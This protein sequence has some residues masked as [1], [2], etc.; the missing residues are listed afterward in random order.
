ML[1]STSKEREE[2]VGHVPGATVGTIQR[3]AARE[4]WG[5]GGYGC[6]DFAMAPAHHVCECI[7]CICGGPAVKKCYAHSAVAVRGRGRGVELG[8]VDFSRIKKQGVLGNKSQP[9]DW[10][11]HH[12]FPAS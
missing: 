12:S 9:I 1:C 10:V 11:S 4:F 7:F 6:F 8:F 5:N 3:G 2:N